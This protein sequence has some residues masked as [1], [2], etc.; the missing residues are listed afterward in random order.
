MND[1]LK[2][3][4]AVSELSHDNQQSFLRLVLKQI[5][6]LKEQ[7][8]TPNGAISE[9][10]ELYDHLM[11]LNE[12]K[13]MWDPTSDCTHVHVV[14]G[15]SFAG[16]M[17]VALKQQG[18]S[19]A[20]KVITIRENYAIGPLGN[21]DSPEGRRTRSEWFQDN[22]TEAFGTYIS[23]EEEYQGL[24]D[25]LE[26]IP[27][28]AEVIIW[29]SR[30]VREQIGM[31][32][33]MHLLRGK[34]SLI[35]MCD[36]TE[37]CEELFNRPHASI[38]YRNSGEISADGLREALERVNAVRQLSAADI[39]R[40]AEEW[41]EISEQGGIL[42]IWTDGTVQEVPADYYDSYIL[43]KLDDL[44]PASD[45]R[46]LKAPRLIGE[47]MGYCEQDIGDSY[48]EYR[49]REM[50][51]EGVLQIKGVPAGM[52]FYSVRKQRLG[53]GR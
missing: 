9:L 45:H 12:K 29:T 10:I 47:A 46:F 19:A 5:K 52:R 18:W 21:L 48:F 22:I 26:Q 15:D 23:S 30:S 16:S 33:A 17:K 39:K 53:E 38:E 2:I 44:R 28:Q 51:Y 49:L 43:D 31:R 37:I 24:L 25:K 14:V 40:L 8:E 11:E 7:R 13:A 35:R 42:R 36:A 20:H 50:I 4:R 27:D 6:L 32:H 1:M 41:L 34:R 3:K